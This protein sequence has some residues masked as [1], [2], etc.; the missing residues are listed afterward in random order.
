MKLLEVMGSYWNFCCCKD[1]FSLSANLLKAHFLEFCQIIISLTSSQFSQFWVCLFSSY[2]SHP[3]ICHCP[4]NAMF[5]IHWWPTIHQW[6]D[7]QLSFLMSKSLYY[8]YPSSLPN[9]ARL[10]TEKFLVLPT[11]SWND[12]NTCSKFTI[13]LFFVDKVFI[14]QLI[15]YTVL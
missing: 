7:L 9:L 10:H 15:T 11:K 2:S 4:K 8:I 3:W 1:S 12:T 13:F 14:V 5:C 6:T